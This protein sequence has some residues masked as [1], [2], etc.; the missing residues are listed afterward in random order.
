MQSIKSPVHSRR[1]TA[2]RGVLLAAVGV[3]AAAVLTGSANAVSAA[4]SASAVSIVT[5]SVHGSDGTLYTATN[6]LVGPAW[7]DP[8]QEFL[9]VWTGAVNPSEPD[10]LAVVN[11]NKTSPDYGKIVNTVT[12]GPVTGNEPH[13]MQYVWHKGDMV[14]AG[15]L[16][17]DMVYVFDVSR[18]PMVRLAGVSTP[19]DHP[20]GSAPDAFQTLSD[21]TAY[22]TFM[23][24][25]AV[26]GPCR[27]TDGEVRVGNGLDGSPGE[28]VRI[29]PRGQTLSEMPAASAAGEDPALC[30]DVPA[31]PQATCANPHGIA[32]RPD[33]NRMVTADLIEVRNLLNPGANLPDPG[34]FRTS[35]RIFDITDRNRP[36]LV[37]TSYLPTGP[38]VVST[39]IAQENREVME[40]ATP[41]LPQHRGAFASTMGGGAIYYAPDITVA[42]PR[43]REVLDETA[44]YNKIDPASQ[45]SGALDGASWLQVSPDDR[46]LFQTVMGSAPPAGSQTG[47]VFVLDISKL[48]AAGDSTSCSIDTLQEAASGG[49]APDCP[50]LVSV[51][52]LQGGVGD[53]FTNVGPHWGA[54]D[55]FRPGPGGFYQ[56]TNDATRFAT[57][58]YF[59]KA[60]GMDGDHEVCM[61]DF[62]PR[63]GLSVD[64]SFQ[65]EFTHTPCLDFNR[66]MWPHGEAGPARPHG[67]LF[68]VPDADI[69]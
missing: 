26:S 6:H 65:D 42:R 46:Y 29:G 25:P 14:Y 30:H 23:G 43:W 28:I 1:G 38:R 33:L 22:G 41:N 39:P 36:R 2:K 64:T 3:L 49:D 48:L 11:A 21:G 59:V 15:G 69:R 9:L 24:G 56:E 52:P 57:S 32:I 5:S 12:L 13:H 51:L 20:C 4:G 31:L 54:F 16:L 8:R 47:M 50:A 62:S 53:S 18:V 63:H 45:V 68:V 61:I 37:S 27:Y 17:S 66:T 10:F 58:D 19:Q 67:V 60:F 7:R 40:T 34:I 55:N 35:V 44:V